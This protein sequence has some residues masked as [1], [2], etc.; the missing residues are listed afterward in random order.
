MTSLHRLSP[1]L[2]LLT[3]LTMPSL[4]IAAKPLST[5]AVASDIITAN[6]IVD[7]DTRGGGASPV[8]IVCWVSGDADLLKAPSSETKT[9]NVLDRLTP[10]AVIRTGE[11]AQV[12]LVFLDGERYVLGANSEIQVGR[13]GVRID[14]GSVHQLEPVPAVAQLPR[15]AKD[16]KPGRRPAA[17]RIRQVRVARSSFELYPRDQAT[18][19]HDAPV[20]Q[21]RA[22]PLVERYDVEVHDVR[23]RDIYSVELDVRPT[24]T[25]LVRVEIPNGV[26]APETVYHLRVTSVAMGRRTLH[27]DTLFSTTSRQDARARHQLA[28][29]AATDDDP[30]LHMLLADV[31]YRLG[32]RREACDA[33]SRSVDHEP[34]P[35]AWIKVKERFGCDERN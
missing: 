32:L 26:L 16:Q 19:L 13:K 17:G 18:L 3:W 22:L 21:F 10:G 34:D 12:M 23:G 15:L 7:I 27:G 5:D 28:R 11:D 35:S 2:V 30:G 29:Q 4:A 20:L 25:D 31:D 33:L 24:K 14:A 8:A 6:F 9:L 1:C